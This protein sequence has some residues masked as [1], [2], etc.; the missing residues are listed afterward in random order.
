MRTSAGAGVF[1]A[2]SGLSLFPAPTILTAPRVK[3]STE[4]GSVKLLPHYVQR[5]AGPNLL[6]W[7]YASDAKG[8]AFHSNIGCSRDGVVISDAEGQDKFAVNVRWNVEDFGYI[9]ITADNGGEFYELPARGRERSYNLNFELAKS[10][11]FR[12]KNRRREFEKT[13]WS[14][15]REVEGY[16]SISEEFYNDA[17]RSGGE[18]RRGSLS[19][20]SLTYAMWGSEMME[21]EKARFEV[22]RLPGAR[23][24]FAFGC[25]AR[26]FYQ[27]YQDRFLELFPELFNYAMVTYVIKGDG[28]M[29]DFEPAEGKLNFATRDVLVRKLRER[30]IT[31][32]GRTIFWFYDGN[33]PDWLKSKSYDD[34]KR[35]VE[36]H[37][38]QV[39]SHYPDEMVGWEIFNEFHDWAV[40]VDITPEQSVELVK[41]ACDV[42]RDVNP[43]SH[44]IINNCCPFAEY[45]QLGRT[46]GGVAKYPQ[47][48]PWE[49]TR[50]LVDAG[51]DFTML[52]QQM[53]FPYRDLQDIMV[54]LE[55]MAEFG[56]PVQLSEVGAPG[57]P[58][59]ESVKTGKVGFPEEPFIWH[60]PWDE[61]L[62]ADWLEATCT[63]AYSKPWIVNYSWFDL[64]DRGAFQS[65]GG[66]LRN[67]KGE[68]KAAWHRFKNLQ[69]T[70]KG[71][72]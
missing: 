22:N 48:T 42:A 35:Y 20:Q 54:L 59:N 4:G 2:A 18:D 58:T 68:K 29:S 36:R 51:V 12:N 8:D 6:D 31:V 56:K 11:V 7:A 10:R 40:E 26:S 53:Y 27:M 67:E 30:A 16:L 9:F 49:F 57:G 44:R 41:L 24:D 63:L 17:R 13:G 46:S 62:Q 38:R 15:S 47:R 43:K 39:V 32:Q 21:L 52:G 71:L 25:D 37:T 14:P 5:G 28:M 33:T 45:V 50:D 69:T 19:Q 61:E 70:W 72:E 55:R 34:L 66:I 1:L 64:L 65:N 23:T 3:R 60:R